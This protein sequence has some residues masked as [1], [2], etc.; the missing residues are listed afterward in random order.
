MQLNQLLEC[1]TSSCHRWHIDSDTVVAV[2]G[3]L[4]VTHIV[5]ICRARKGL[6]FYLARGLDILEAFQR[7][8]LFAFM[9]LVRRWWRQ[10]KVEHNRVQAK[11][12]AQ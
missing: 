2:A 12:V 8:L 5:L 4:L 3:I 10:I 9:P 1:S 7:S 11:V 6:T